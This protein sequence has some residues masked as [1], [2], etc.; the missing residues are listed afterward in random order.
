MCR[1]LNCQIPISDS[2][3]AGEWC[4]N[5]WKQIPLEIRGEILSTPKGSKDNDR[6]V[7]GALRALKARASRAEFE[8]EMEEVLGG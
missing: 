4:R 5:D 8:A 1:A 6:A 3:P 2:D 7:L